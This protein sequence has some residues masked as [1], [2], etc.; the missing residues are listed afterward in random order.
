MLPYL[1]IN[2]ARLFH[3]SANTL[4][5]S[6]FLEDNRRYRMLRNQEVN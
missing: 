2:E 3:H 5:K 1:S 4:V 6:Y